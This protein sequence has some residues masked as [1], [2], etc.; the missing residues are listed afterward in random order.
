MNIS[1]DDLAVVGSSASIKY[2]I[3]V[4]TVGPGH[5]PGWGY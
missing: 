1:N 3:V 4:L 2:D 5:Q